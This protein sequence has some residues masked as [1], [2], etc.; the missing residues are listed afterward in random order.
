VLIGR[1]GASGSSLPGRQISSQHVARMSASDMRV[2][3]R[4]GPGCRGACHHRASAI[5]LVVGRAFAR[6]VGSP[7]LRL[8]TASLANCANRGF[9]AATV[10]GHFAWTGPARAGRLRAGPAHPAP[11]GPLPDFAGAGS[12]LVHFHFA[13]TGPVAAFSWTGPAPGPLAPPVPEQL[14]R[15]VRARPVP[16]SLPPPPKPGIA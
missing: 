4:R 2:F 6:P 9:A 10:S 3:S 8:A 14:A 7:G 15:V 11:A 1:T 5:A 16:V 12:L 13:R